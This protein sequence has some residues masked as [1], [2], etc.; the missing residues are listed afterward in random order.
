MEMAENKTE[1]YEIIKDADLD[2]MMNYLWKNKDLPFI[3]E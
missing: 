1:I 2:K 3:Q